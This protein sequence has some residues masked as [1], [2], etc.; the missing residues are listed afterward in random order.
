MLTRR[1]SSPFF[2]RERIRDQGPGALTPSA[3]PNHAQ[4]KTP[5]SDHQ[6]NR[7]PTTKRTATGDAPGD[8]EPCGAGKIGDAPLDAYMRFFPIGAGKN[9]PTRTGTLPRR[10]NAT[11]P[12]GP[13]GNGDKERAGTEEAADAGPPT[14]QANPNP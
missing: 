11:E 14:A 2:R 4:Q 1:D 7:A 5:Q 12:E 10:E 6:T 3:L 9:E 8:L 13:G